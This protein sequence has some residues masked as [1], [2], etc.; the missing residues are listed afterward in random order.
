MTGEEF[1]GQLDDFAQAWLP[2]RD[3]VQAALDKRFDVDQSGSVIVFNQV[4]MAFDETNF[5]EL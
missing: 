1:L 5:T 2:A 4:S 3:I